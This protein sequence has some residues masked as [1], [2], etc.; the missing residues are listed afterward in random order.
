MLSHPESYYSTGDQTVLIDMTTE[1]LET[2]LA[3]E[4]GVLDGPT[5]D[6]ADDIDRVVLVVND[7]AFSKDFATTG[8]WP[9]SLTGGVRYLSVSVQG[10][11]NPTPQF[12]HGLSHQLGL[13]DLYI[14]PNVSFPKPHVVDGWDNMAK[15]ENGVHPLTWSKELASWVT[16]SGARIVYIP[17][18][19]PAHPRAGQPAI[20]LAYQTIATSG[21]NAA[22]AIGLTEGVT[23]FEEETQFYWIEARSPSLGNAD[24]VVPQDGVIMYYANKRIPQGQAPVILRDHVP[25]T[26]TLD[27]AA[28]P[29]GGSESPAGTGITATVTGKLP[30][31]GGYRVTVDYAPPV[32]DYD[33]YLRQGAHPWQ[34]PDVWID[35]QPYAGTPTPGSEEP[36]G[37][38]ENRLYARVHNDG[39]AT[40]YH[41]EVRF[42]LSAPYHTVGGAGSFDLYKIVYI[43]EIPPGAYRD[44]YVVWTPAGSGDPHNCAK[45]DLPNLIND[46]NP[47]NDSA[48]QNFTVQYSNHSS[49]YDLVDFHFQVRNATKRPSLVYF[50]A[51][52]LPRG[53]AHQVIPA[54][55]LLQPNETA[56]GEL[57]MHPPITA[58]SCTDHEVELTA[59]T[60]RGDT[61]VRLGGTTVDAALRDRTLLSL[62]TL[63]GSCGGLAGG[64]KQPPP[65]R[66]PTAGLAVAPGD[67]ADGHVFGWGQ[68][69]TTLPPPGYTRLSPEVVDAAEIEHRRNEA[70]LLP[71][72]RERP[73]PCGLIGA[74][75]CTSPPRPHQT[76]LVRY[77]DPSGN[78]VYHQ[79]ET[80]SLGCYQDAYIVVEGGAWKATASFPGDRCAGPVRGTVGLTVPLA[81]TGDQDHDGLPDKDEVQ[82][83]ADGD[84]VPNVL[85]PDSD[86]D[87]VPDG[88]EAPGDADHDGVSNVVDPDS[89]NDGVPDG[90]DPSPYH[91][92]QLS[93]PA[94]ARALAACLALVLLAGLMLVAS[95][96]GK[97]WWLALLA[98]VLLLVAHLLA[99]GRCVDAFVRPAF[100]LMLVALAVAIVLW[101]R[102]HP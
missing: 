36:T 76:V 18:P 2:L 89:D 51:D 12:A 19:D 8:H 7:P 74:V 87:G 88:A 80:D 4:P 92:C 100:F 20:Q 94:R 62:G 35:H 53:W 66:G 46:T 56:V 60:P 32:T 5:A 101:R 30:A 29:V 84:G 67:P 1:V 50:R 33:V 49:P 47:A 54:K 68:A 40:A 95:L 24:A 26:P 3:S 11:N 86:N 41:V 90:S 17:R 83:D 71:T 28:I 85:D 93:R 27:D 10:P 39:P 72:V 70:A 43:D 22:I 31:N 42:L 57:R 37:G 98:A 82:G 99:Q 13:E 59:W 65:T 97:R 16:S 58:P 63:F 21:Q 78:P 6:P 38:E 64:G 52:G 75:G 34:S 44:A 48:Q 61:L 73:R 23:T 81:V 15:P 55:K 69:Q 102:A 14:H 77:R 45:V 91:Y 9:F 25:G 96:F 79:V